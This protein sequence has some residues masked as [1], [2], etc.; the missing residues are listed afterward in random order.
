MRL[1][2]TQI[3]L[4]TKIPQVISGKFALI[5]RVLCIAQERHYY[6]AKQANMFQGTTIKGLF[7]NYVIPLLKVVFGVFVCAGGA[8]A[9]MMIQTN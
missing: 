1:R 6:Y 2:R 7:K 8:F 5:D 4:I 3:P 9:A